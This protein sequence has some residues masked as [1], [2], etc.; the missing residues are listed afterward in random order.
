MILR[1]RDVDEPTH[2]RI[3]TAITEYAE[4]ESRTD[5]KEMTLPL[6][7]EKRFDAIGPTI[8][9]ELR[10]R[11]LWAIVLT[12][13]A[14]VLYIAWAF[15]RIS[16]P[17]ASW[18]YGVV[19]VVALAHDLAIPA[20]AFALLGRFRGVE[21]DILFITALL[22]VLGFSV[23]DTIV[24]FDRIRENLRTP[25]KNERYADTVNRSIRETIVRS[26]LTSCT[27]LLVLTIV[28]F[29]GGASTR[30]FTLAL[31]IGITAG[32]YSSIFVASPLLVLWN[33]LTKQK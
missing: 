25:R 24:V 9:A 31:I 16:K 12:V 10:T 17:V 19:A 11:A 33:D 30:Y 5:K 27:V 6:V 32:T 20:G 21:I 2:Q 3:L 8:G 22:T 1:F 23:H 29:L 14:I 15:R 13:S 28:F 4:K 18:K 7:T 26:I